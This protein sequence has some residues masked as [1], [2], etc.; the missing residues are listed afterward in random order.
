MR[1]LLLV[2]L[3]AA[4]LPQATFAQGPQDRP[5]T[6]AADGG[7]ILVMPFENPKREPRLHWIGEAAALLLADQ[8]S[9]RGLAAIRRAERVRAFEELH[10]PSNAVLSR[11]T[12]IKVGELV[13]ASEVIVGSIALDGSD[14]VVEANSIRIDVGRLQPHVRDRAPL[15]E[16]EDLFERVA[17]KLA[18][19]AKLREARPARPPLE[20]FENYVKGLMAESAAARATFLEA[21]VRLHPAYDRA[22]LAL[23]EVRAD[24]GDHTGALAVARAVPASSP[25]APRAAFLAAVSMLELK[26]Y[27]GSVHGLY[28][29]DA[30]GDR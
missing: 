18:R 13:G 25:L 14:L 28:E 10:L 9:A 29:I 1:R 17:G 3:V 11:A 26:Q 6:P 4:L 16:V 27:R 7:R 15:P 5:A 19:D 21:A 12:V 8:L 30:V 24:Q 22:H 20:A 2:A 23:W